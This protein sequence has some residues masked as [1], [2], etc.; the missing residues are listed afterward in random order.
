MKRIFRIA[1]TIVF[2]VTISEAR[3]GILFESGTLGPTGLTWDGHFVE[4]VGG[5]NVE[6]AAFVGVRF[7]LT[8][9][10][11]TTHIGGHFLQRPEANPQGDGSFF[12][13]II[14]LVDENDFPDS[15]NLSTPDVVGSTLLTFP[16][17]SDEV[18]GA[19]SLRLDPGWYALVFGSG[20]FG[21]SAGGVA[22]R[23]NSDIGSP[24]YISFP[25]G[26]WQGW[27]TLF[28]FLR[29]HRF[30]VRGSIVPEPASVGLIATALL[31]AMV[32]RRPVVNKPRRC[33]EYVLSF[34][35]HSPS[36]DS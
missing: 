12:G 36:F 25:V 1:V 24:T 31:F 10:V 6:R 35:Y 8:Q 19:L 33:F 7:E 5:T 28:S 23:N 26:G 2:M 4:G 17:P 11:V 16:D 18:L 27:T 14:E 34:L 30:V 3:A 20:L 29:D 21:S 32:I 15:G 22:L 13:S 9:P